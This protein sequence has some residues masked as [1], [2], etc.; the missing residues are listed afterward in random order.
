ML[1]A[2]WGV[3]GRKAADPLTSDRVAL[4][5]HTLLLDGHSLVW[6]AE[7]APSTVVVNG[8]I[9][10]AAKEKRSESP[11]ELHSTRDPIRF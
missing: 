10:D 11:N 6:G 1:H 4:A 3:W 9:D 7:K 8:A 2:A 5:R